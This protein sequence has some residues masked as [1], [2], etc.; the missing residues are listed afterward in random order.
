[1]H[2]S[3]HGEVLPLALGIGEAHIDP[4]D[5]FVLDLLQNVLGARHVLSFF[6]QFPLPAGLPRGRLELACPIGPPPTPASGRGEWTCLDRVAVALAGADAQRGFDGDD[7]NLAVADAAGLR[8]GGDRLDHAIGEASSSTTTSS[9]TLGRKS[10]TYSAPRYSSVWPFWRPKP[11]ASVNGDAPT[12][13]DF[14]QRF[15]HFVEL[16]RFDDRFDLFHRR[17]PP[18]SPRSSASTCHRD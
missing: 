11:L 5:L 18:A 2:A 12:H 1:M 13:A 10:T 16:E 17:H 6:L 7:E 14:V 3:A 15:L 4:L 9:F 8:G